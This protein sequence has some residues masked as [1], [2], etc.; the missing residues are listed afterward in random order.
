MGLNAD[1]RAD[2]DHLLPVFLRRHGGL[3]Q[4]STV[5]ELGIAESKVMHAVVAPIRFLPRGLA[6]P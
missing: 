6:E 4:V 1:L 2:H 3:H 5:F